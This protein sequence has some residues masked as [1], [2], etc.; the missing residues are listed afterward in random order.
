MGGGGGGGGW[1]GW[2]GGQGGEGVGEFS[3]KL[4]LH[5]PRE[6]FLNISSSLGGGGGK[7]KLR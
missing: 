2:G 3:C 6:G 1:R 7:C 5:T 4:L